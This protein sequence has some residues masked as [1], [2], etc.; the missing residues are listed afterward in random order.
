[1]E[2][3]IFSALPY[4]FR[5]VFLLCKTLTSKWKKQYKF[6]NNLLKT[7]FFWI[8]G[9]WESHEKTYKEDYILD[10]I[11]DV[12]SFMLNCYKTGRLS[13]YFMPEINLF[14]QYPVAVH[15]NYNLEKKQD[16]VETIKIYDLYY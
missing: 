13:M 3:E 8:L 6:N 7:V 9:K 4:L 11:A 10:M 5:K 1:M 16:S 2:K 14:Q 15:E 12:F